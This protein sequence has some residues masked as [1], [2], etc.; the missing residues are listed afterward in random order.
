MDNDY[1]N[2]SRPR[3]YYVCRGKIRG[4]CGHAHRTLSGALACLR[5][6]ARGCR[7]QSAGGYSDRVVWHVEGPA[8]YKVA[9][10]AEGEA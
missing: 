10:A 3:S 4:D 1:D 7:R 6:D 2:M 8:A 5:R 9:A